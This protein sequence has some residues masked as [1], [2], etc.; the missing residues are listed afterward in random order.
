MKTCYI[1][2]LFSKDGR[3][4]WSYYAGTDCFRALE[5][6]R[7]KTDNPFP[8]PSGNWKLTTIEIY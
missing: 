1:A 3:L 4:L 7:K 6:I 5:I 8:F 2:Q